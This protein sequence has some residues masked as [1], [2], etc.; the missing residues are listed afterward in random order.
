M[1]SLFYS[2]SEPAH[3]SLG[4]S[5]IFRHDYFTSPVY[6][7]CQRGQ[8]EDVC[9][10]SCLGHKNVESGEDPVTSVSRPSTRERLFLPTTTYTLNVSLPYVVEPCDQATYHTL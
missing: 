7:S 8:S 5:L 4:T 9:A 10:C 6:D 1:L 3:S 2:T